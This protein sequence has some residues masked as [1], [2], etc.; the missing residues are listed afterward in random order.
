M[1]RLQWI[2]MAIR[3][4]GEYV[5]R[6]G[7]PDLI[8]A[9]GSMWAGAAAQ[10]I[11]DRT[12]IP[13][14][15]TEHSSK[16]LTGRLPHWG[17]R[18]A[19]PAFRSAACCVAVSKVLAKSLQTAV[20]AG[21][22]E[23][24][25]NSVDPDRFPI[26]RTEQAGPFTFA[27]VGGLVPIK[28]HQDLLAGFARAFQGRP[29]YRLVLV[30]DGPERKSLQGQALDLGIATQVEFA[31]S[32]ERSGVSAVLRDS[33]A[34]VVASHHETFSVAVIE[35]L[36]TGLPVLSTRCGGPEEILDPG[37][38]WLVGKEDGEALVQGL[39]TAARDARSMA[40]ADIRARAI[41]RFGMAAIASRYQALYNALLA[42]RDW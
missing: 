26:R 11:A 19:K 28:G 39:R 13:Y 23:V 30:G 14:L 12:G 32:L 4:F 41:A 16:F 31:G 6:Y 8:H 20:A 37:D 34:L 21:P 40:P 29:E 17:V 22:V 25:P 24:I 9:H 15:L 18:M 10:R 35:A 33:D 2:K 1:Y 38:G 7:K 27:M 3:L 36:A 42:R 5:H